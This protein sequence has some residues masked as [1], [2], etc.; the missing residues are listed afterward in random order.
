[1]SF[2]VEHLATDLLGKVRIIDRSGRISSQVDHLM[3]QGA[4]FC[5]KRLFEFKPAVVG[6][7]R[8]LHGVHLPILQNA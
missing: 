8:N 1:M 7:D 5:Q 6:A 4:Q 2:S 3:A